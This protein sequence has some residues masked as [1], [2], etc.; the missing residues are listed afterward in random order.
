MVSG[1][2]VSNAWVTYHR[3]RDGGSASA[4]LAK[5][6]VIPDDIQKSP[7]FWIKDGDPSGPIGF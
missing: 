2:R 5:V 7:G 6:P 3:L 1:G 4:D